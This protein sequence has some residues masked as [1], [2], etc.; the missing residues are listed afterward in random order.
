MSRTLWRS[1]LLSLLLV[2]LAALGCSS[3]NSTPTQPAAGNAVIYSVTDTCSTGSSILLRFFD[4]GDGAIFPDA[5]DAYTQSAGTTISYPLQP[6]SA[7]TQTCYGGQPN[8]DTN[9]LFWGVGL[10]ESS[11]CSNCCN[12]VPTT[13]VPTYDVTLGPVGNLGCAV[14][15]IIPRGEPR[16]SQRLQKSATVAQPVVGTV[17]PSAPTRRPR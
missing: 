14:V 2:A 7:G 11:T 9:N 16:E 3:S 6:V 5:N 4:D 8:P 17:T 10:L 12:T 13:G 1:F 15:S